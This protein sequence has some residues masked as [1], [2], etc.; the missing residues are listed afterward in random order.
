MLEALHTSI[1]S[2]LP[3]LLSSWVFPQR[4]LEFSDA[5]Q[6]N[7]WSPPSGCSL[8]LTALTETW[9]SQRTRSLWS[10]LILFPCPWISYP[11]TWG[12]VGSFSLWLPTDLSPA[13]FPNILWSDIRL[14]PPLCLLWAFPMDT[15]TV[16][17]IPPLSQLLS[18]HHWLWQC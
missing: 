7:L 15:Q 1:T 5:D 6:Q 16:P 10:P 9:V 8:H 12:W 4:P 13:R 2:P 18:R 17:L 11:C 3:L 14:E